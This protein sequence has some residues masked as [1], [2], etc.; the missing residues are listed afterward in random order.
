[1]KDYDN[2]Y[3][4]AWDKKSYATVSTRKKVRRRQAEFS[5]SKNFLR[6]IF[7][8]L[9]HPTLDGGMRMQ[10]EEKESEPVEPAEEES[11]PEEAAA[12]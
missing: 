11:G 10:E 8:E 6:R 5:L 4:L 1:V 2:L 9:L 7:F 3:V 12:N